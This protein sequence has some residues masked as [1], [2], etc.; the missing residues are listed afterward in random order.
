MREVGRLKSDVTHLSA[1]KPF[2]PAAADTRS[3]QPTLHRH[4]N[5]VREKVRRLIIL[6]DGENKPGYAAGGG[7]STAIDGAAVCRCMR[8][9]TR[10]ARGN[11][12]FNKTVI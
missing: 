11:D 12:S 2:S 10:T 7:T 4:C 5:A 6:S 3:Q 9:L 8:R 1:E